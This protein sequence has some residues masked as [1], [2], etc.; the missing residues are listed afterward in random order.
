[1]LKKIVFAAFSL[2]I[3]G[4]MLARELRSQKTVGYFVYGNGPEKVLVM[5]DWMG[6]SGNYRPILRYL[7]TSIFT[8]VFIDVRGYGMS[9]HLGGPYTAEQVSADAFALA[10]KLGW[11]RFHVVGHSM[12]GMVVQR[13]ALQDRKK[14]AGKGRLK[15]V[16]AITPVSADGYPATPEDLAFFNAVIFNETMSQQAFAGLT[17]KRHSS[18]WTYVK[19]K[20]HLETASREALADYL[21]MWVNEDISKEIARAR[22]QTPLLVIGGRQ[23]LPGF[24]ES[25]FE[26]T[27]A[28]WYPNVTFRYITDAG[29]YPM[30]ETP[31]YLASLIEEFLV[32]NSGPAY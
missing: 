4:A 20:R 3:V 18:Q 32:R 31:V 5:H 14:P 23:D 27:F 26:K 1:M 10:D 21:K 6:D 12:T 7:D 29:H 22:I 24:Q 30:Q 15:S 8:Y 25:H 19:T 9:R 16:V 17:G 11:Q 13:M 28:Q 2:G